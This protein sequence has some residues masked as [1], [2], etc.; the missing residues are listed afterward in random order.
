MS[1]TN[2]TST[3]EDLADEKDGYSLVINMT[4]NTKLSADSFSKDQ[5][6]FPEAAIAET[7]D[8]DV[9]SA[10]T[11]EVEDNLN[12]E[13]SV[14]DDTNVKLNSQTPIN[15]SHVMEN[16]MESE[17]PVGI[18][19]YNSFHLPHCGQVVLS[20]KQCKL[21]FVLNCIN[22]YCFPLK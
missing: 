3:A 11:P 16:Q 21:L 14:E 5:I 6:F 8:Y 17:Q 12:N 20:G 1:D 4:I 13:I 22:I 2:Y 15:E 19:S 18:M 10:A 9:I 7:R